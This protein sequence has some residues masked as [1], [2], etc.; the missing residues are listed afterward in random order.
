[1]TLEIFTFYVR[2]LRE[3]SEKSN[4]RV[5]RQAKFYIKNIKRSFCLQPKEQLKEIL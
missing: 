1:M 2:W 4:T 5:I 3:S